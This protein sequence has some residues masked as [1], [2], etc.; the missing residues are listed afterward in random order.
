MSSPQFV[1]LHV[2]S[3]FS[4][5]DGACK[6][7]KLVGAAQKLAMPA[8]ALTD[9]GNLHGVIQFYSAAKDAG[10][11]P[12]IGYEAY[13]A[14]GSRLEKSAGGEAFYHL[15]LLAENLA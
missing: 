2:H 14:P 9:H 1:H 4:L 6:I 7:K 5:L 3:D 15:T 12:I 10:V 13:V 8:I 11:K